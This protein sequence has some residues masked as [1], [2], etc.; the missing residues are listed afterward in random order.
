ML[1]SNSKFHYN[2]LQTSVTG[3]AAR[4]ALRTML[5]AVNYTG[6]H[7]SEVDD[8][9]DAVSSHRNLAKTFLERTDPQG[10]SLMKL[11]KLMLGGLPGGY[12]LGLEMALHEEDERRAMEGEMAQLEQRWREA[13]DIAA[14]SDSLLLPENIEDQL[15]K[16]HE[17]Q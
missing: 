8:A 16:L 15:R 17:Q 12:R 14:I 9:V 3:T 10:R 7:Q 4:D 11:P 1:L 13:E 5:P 6:G 2:L